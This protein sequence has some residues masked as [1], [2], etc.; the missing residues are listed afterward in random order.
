VWGRATAVWSPWHV[1]FKVLFPQSSF[2]VI[3]YKDSLKLLCETVFAPDLWRGK[4]RAE[5]EKEA[6]LIYRNI[7]ASIH[8]ALPERDEAFRIARLELFDAAMTCWEHVR[9]DP[10]KINISESPAKW[11]PYS[12]LTPSQIMPK[13]KTPRKPSIKGF[14]A[15]I[16]SGDIELVERL[17][18]KGAA[19][20][21]EHCSEFPACCAIRTGRV[22]ILALLLRHGVDPRYHDEA[23]SCTAVF[24]NQRESLNLL[25][26]TVFDPDLWRGK[27]RAEIEKEAD[28]MYQNI[29]DTLRIEL[30]YL[31]EGFPR[32]RG[33]AVSTPSD[34][35]IRRRHDMLRARPSRSAQD[36]DQR[37]AG[38]RQNPLAA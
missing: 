15:A 22:H 24:Y 13:S 5:I 4:S 11:G 26:T 28:L 27:S 18:A 19:V 17:I 20:N 7:Q 30:P 31:L 36:Q 32:G 23:L 1:L 8:P 14:L 34:C 12:S 10:P 3:L 16:E 9:P 37:R 38:Q 29:D 25:A 35:P 33:S 2:S 6:D 21:S